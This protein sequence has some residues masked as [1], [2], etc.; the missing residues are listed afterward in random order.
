MRC[1]PNRYYEANFKACILKGTTRSIRNDERNQPT[2]IDPAEHSHFNCTG[3]T[4]G[5]YPDE[6]DC[7]IYH[8]C[9]RSDLYAPFDHLTVECPHSTAYDSHMKSCT[10]KAWKLCEKRINCEEPMR[11]RETRSCDRYFL[12]YR[13]QVVK[14][15]CPEGFQFN[16]NSEFCEPKNLV[17]C[18]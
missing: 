14:I 6:T 12:C 15:L 13:N 2:I 9:L 11:F 10:K 18:E 17:K 3:K 4:P 16:E 1:G 5:K 8:L 7:H